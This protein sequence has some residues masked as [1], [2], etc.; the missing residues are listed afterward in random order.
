MTWGSSCLFQYVDLT[1]NNDGYADL[2]RQLSV[3]AE[4][5][6][7]KFESLRI[8]LAWGKSYCLE[9]QRFWLV[10][11]FFRSAYFLFPLLT[12]F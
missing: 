3:L 10:G 4:S 8:V 5:L 12:D 7:S 6:E 2:V 1:Q 11:S 9:S